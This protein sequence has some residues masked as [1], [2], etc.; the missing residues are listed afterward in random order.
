MNATGIEQVLSEIRRLSVEAQGDA[1]E[2]AQSA[3]FGEILTQMIDSANGNELRASELKRAYTVGQDD[4]A[5]TDVMVAQAEARI[6]FETI[7]QVRNNLVSAYRD[8]MNMPL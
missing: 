2:N 5:L 8:I 4:V 6:S 7:M 1:S 3:G